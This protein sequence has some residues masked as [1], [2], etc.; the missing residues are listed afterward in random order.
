METTQYL[1]MKKN[2]CVMALTMI[3]KNDGE[4]PKDIYRVLGCIVSSLM[5]NYVF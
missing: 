5:D 3:H 2:I 1:L 4:K